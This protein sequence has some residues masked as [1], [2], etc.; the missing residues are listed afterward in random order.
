MTNDTIEHI[1]EIIAIK[2]GIASVR[3]IQTSACSECHAKNLCSAA[4]QKEKVIEAELRNDDFSIGDTVNV[5]GHKNLGMRAV[6]LAYVLPFAIVVVTMAVL[7][8]FVANELIVGSI[9]LA[10]LI[11]YFIVMRLMKNKISAKFKFYVTNI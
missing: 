7:G 11:P 4:D 3:I 8:R 9:S 10:T 5:V 1:G 2:D 6:L